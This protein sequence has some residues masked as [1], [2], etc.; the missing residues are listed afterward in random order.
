MTPSARN[1]GQREGKGEKKKSE[2]RGFV[3]VTCTYRDAERNLLQRRP[4]KFLDD[5]NIRPPFKS[6]LMGRERERE[7]KREGERERQVFL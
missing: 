3:R 4:R 2:R 5:E 7:R 1:S 6:F